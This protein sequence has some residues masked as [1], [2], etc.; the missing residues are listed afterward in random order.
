MSK[1][2]IHYGL[3]AL[4]MA[5]GCDDAEVKADAEASAEQQA[6]GKT[7]AEPKLVAE[8]EFD[9]E[10]VAF[11]VKKGKVK[12]AKALEKQ[13]NS[14]KSGINK[15]DIDDDGKVDKIAVLEV[16]EAGKT[17]FEIKV[18]PSTKAKKKKDPDVYVNI[19][20]IELEPVEADNNVKVNVYYD[21]VVEHKVTEVYTFSFSATFSEES[22]KVENA[23][24][25]SWV[26]TNRPLY[27]SSTYYVEVHIDDGGCWPP[28]HCKHM[29]WSHDSRVEIHIDGHHHYKHKKWKKGRHHGKW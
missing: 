29:S 21:N 4:L 6:D 27:V 7:E 24:F 23:V 2:A 5:S 10:S 19:A 16:R 9:L 26:Y 15:I 14:K 18:L 11:L 25:V 20:Y 8:G 1:R 13:I 22:V 3:F 17:K 28:G 12:N